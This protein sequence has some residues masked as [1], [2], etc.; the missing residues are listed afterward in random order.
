MRILRDEVTPEYPG[1]QEVKST[2]AEPKVGLRNTNAASS[3]GYRDK[4]AK[5]GGLDP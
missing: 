1:D 3:M 5:D 2:A 4:K